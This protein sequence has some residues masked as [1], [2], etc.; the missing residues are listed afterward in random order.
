MADLGTVLQLAGHLAQVPAEHHRIGVGVQQV[1]LQVVLRALLPQHALGHQ[2]VVVGGGTGF[3]DGHMDDIGV[4]LVHILAVLL[5]ELDGRCGRHTLGCA[6][7]IV[8]LGVGAA[9][10]LNVI[11]IVQ[12]DVEAHDVDAVLLGQFL[13]HVAGGIGQDRDLAHNVPHFHS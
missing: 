10:P 2:G 3:I 5:A 12:Q 6:H 8:E 9:F 13:R 11:H 4:A 7:L 1:D